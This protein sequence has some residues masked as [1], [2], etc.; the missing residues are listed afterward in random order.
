MHSIFNSA[1]EFALAD[2]E[3]Q[4]PQFERFLQ[5]VAVAKHTRNYA[6]LKEK[7]ETY[8]KTHNRER[9]PSRFNLNEQ[10]EE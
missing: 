5:E 7:V 3:S 4:S 6:D 8:L 2:F 9:D 10:I 1:G